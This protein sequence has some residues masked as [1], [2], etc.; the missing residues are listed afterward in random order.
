MKRKIW[1]LISLIMCLSSNQLRGQSGQYSYA[2]HP[3]Y[4]FRLGYGLSKDDFTKS[5]P[6]PAIKFKHDT[7]SNSAVSFSVTASIVYDEKS[8]REKFG[9]DTKIE[10]R[11][12]GWKGG[13]SMNQMN[14]QFF[15]MNSLN[16]IISA[17]TEFG[18]VS[19]SDIE[20]TGQ[21]AALLADKEQFLERYGS[22]Y[23]YEVRRGAFVY[24]VINISNVSQETQN[25]LGF[26]LSGSVDFGV[27][28]GGA[29]VS[30]N[31]ELFEASKSGRINV[32]VF[33]VGGAGAAG[34][35]DLIN[36]LTPDGDNLKFIKEEVGRYVKTLSHKAAVPIGYKSATYSQLGIQYKDPWT[37]EREAIIEK[38]ATEYKRLSRISENLESLNNPDQIYKALLIDS[39]QEAYITQTN[40]KIKE[41]VVALAKLHKAIL[42]HP[43]SLFNEP[44]ILTIDFKELLP[45]FP[46]FYVG[47]GAP[48][49]MQGST[50]IFFTTEALTP[51]QPPVL[52]GTPLSL[53]SPDFTFLA[54]DN[55]K[56]FFP[57]IDDIKFFNGEEMVG[58]LKAYSGI[59][60][61]LDIKESGYFNKVYVAHAARIPNFMLFAIHL[62]D[63]F[64]Q[65]MNTLSQAGGGMINYFIQI[66]DVFGHSYKI[67]FASLIITPG[68]PTSHSMHI[69]PFNELITSKITFKIERLHRLANRDS[70][71]AN[72]VFDE[73]LGDIPKEYKVCQSLND[74][75]LSGGLIHLQMIGIP[76]DT[77]KIHFTTKKKSTEY[78][79]KN[80][81][82][83]TRMNIINHKEEIILD[84]N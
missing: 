10:A 80:L 35:G 28:G 27:G 30:V 49:I 29:S 62:S 12:L 45:K 54:D 31:Q 18:K 78:P 8:M 83:D 47:Q 82:I 42:T 52:I 46:R 67:P 53:F 43:D 48:N 81:T 20:L 16:V 58:S 41:R 77:I 70:L 25:K 59:Q 23:I 64:R 7:S 6:I 71:C 65:K 56:S 51:W 2:Y 74:I 13:A 9:I 32:E 19:L 34:F 24:L 1:V 55:R 61:K 33:G 50:A 72:F 66:D 40:I 76:F 21:A 79:L 68:T 3:E 5:F 73:A 26:G 75:R 22:E 44:Q 84:P 60:G 17:K 38:V 37:M 4:S 11:G 36:K 69:Q 15:K 63:L 57:I 39:A 14:D